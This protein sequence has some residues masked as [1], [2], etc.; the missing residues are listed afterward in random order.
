MEVSLKKDEFIRLYLKVFLP[1][2]E[3]CNKIIKLKNDI[4][5]EEIFDYHMNRWET[6]A[7]E[8][9]YTRDNHSGKFSQVLDG[10][11]YIVKRDHRLGFYQMTG[12]SYQIVDLIHE[13]IRINHEN[14]WDFQIDDKKYWIKYDDELYSNLSNKIMIE[15]RRIL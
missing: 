13:L 7:G 2:P 12:V 3:I 10:S 11:N 6:I 9:Y 5:N 1:I 4:E 14:A 15:M 8:H